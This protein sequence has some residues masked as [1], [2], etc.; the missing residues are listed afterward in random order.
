VARK[1]LF[2]RTTRPSTGL[3]IKNDGCIRHD[4]ISS[5]NQIPRPPN[6]DSIAPAKWYV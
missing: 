4:L 2:R 1:K 5:L 6:R 3:C